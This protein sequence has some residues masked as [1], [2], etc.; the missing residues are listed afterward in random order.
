MPTMKLDAILSRDSDRGEPVRQNTFEIMIDK[1]QDLC[2][3]NVVSF[4]MANWTVSQKEKHHMNVITKYAGKGNFDTF[5][6]IVHDTIDPDA[7]RVVHDWY[8]E[9]FDPDTGLMGFTTDYKTGGTVTQFD[10]KGN[11]VR[12]WTLYGVWPTTVNFG[13]GNYEVDGEPIQ[14]TLSLSVDYIKLD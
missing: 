5:D 8:K 14:I 6:L 4:P 11:E 13:E 9:V 3:L 7:G 2:P 10:V 12:N 1:I